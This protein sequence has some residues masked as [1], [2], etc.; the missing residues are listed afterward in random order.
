MSLDGSGSADF[1]E[2]VSTWPHIYREAEPSARSA[3]Q[4][5]PKQVMSAAD[6]EL[7][8]DTPLSI[9]PIA[10]A[11]STQENLI[12]TEVTITPEGIVTQVET[13]D[14]H[15]DAKITPLPTLSLSPAPVDT[16]TDALTDNDAKIEEN[17]NRFNARERIDY[18]IKKGVP[19]PVIQ[20]DPLSD[21]D[22]RSLPG[23]STSDKAIKNSA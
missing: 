10:D 23:T 9:R 2:F 19:R 6:G 7:R 21:W 1:R 14:G 15:V 16:S 22:T 17:L 13:I 4:T 20:L 12:Y 3:E 18:S 11:D 8:V 5:I